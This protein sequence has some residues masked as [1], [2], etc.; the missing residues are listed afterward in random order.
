MIITITAGIFLVL[1]LATFSWGTR[2]SALGIRH[3]LFV[4]AWLC[5][6]LT[7]TLVI[8]SAFPASTATGTIFGVTLGGA[9]AFVLLVWTAALRAGN[10]AAKRD[11]REL[12]AFRKAAE[13]APLPT[14]VVIERQETFWYRLRKNAE[15]NKR[16]I[17]IITGDVRRVH[18]VDAWVNSENTDMM[19][20]RIH[21]FS[22]SGII[23]YEG[24]R[25]DMT[26][27]IVTDVIADELASAIRDHRPVTPG[28]AIVTS[29]GELTRTHGVR[30]V[31]HSASVEGQPGAGYRPIR[32]LDRAVARA[33]EAAEQPIPEGGTALEPARSVLFPLVGAGSAGGR[34]DEIVRT[35]L[36]AAVEHLS[37][38]TSA[39]PEQVLFL[40]YTDRELAACRRV[41]DTCAEIVKDSGP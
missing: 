7:A 16:W 34:L 15:P 26:G 5:A 10:R 30:F 37:H 1:C 24:A 18:G 13:P 31:I 12:A 29:A 40:A 32:E 4:F 14:P 23:R 6:A 19:M 3:T 20:S 41:L 39:R 9:G 8:F 33:L 38:S 28:I 21:D 36:L 22:M 27:R 35:L 11:A 2:Q 17:G 25:R